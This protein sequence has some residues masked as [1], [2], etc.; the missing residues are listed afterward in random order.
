MKTT[1]IKSKGENAVR[2]AVNALKKGGIVIYP[3]ETSYGIG[4]DATKSNA[5]RKIFRLKA[6]ENG[7]PISIIISSLA[8]AK[9]YAFIDALSR[10]LIKQFMPGPLTLISKKKNLPDILSKNTIAWRIPSHPFALALVKKSG[11]PITATSANLSGK[12]QLY[13]I[14]EVAKTFSGC[15]DLIIDAG[16]L[17]R[18]SPS[19][20]FD[21]INQKILRKGPVKEKGIAAYLKD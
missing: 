10:K 17:P 11:R 5:I 12:R 16:N 13:R 21:T 3:T 20:V 2:A 14:K 19:T 9:K 7:K 1:V 18:R 8:M 4:A 6:R 15:V